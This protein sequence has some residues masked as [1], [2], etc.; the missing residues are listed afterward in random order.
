MRHFAYAAAWKKFEPMWDF[1]IRT[2]RVARMLP[3][4][5]TILDGRKKAKR[6]KTTS[7]PASPRPSVSGF[8]KG[9]AET[10][11]VEFASADLFD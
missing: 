9:Q 6:Q 11:V 1:I 7:P 3:L 10:P 8:P 4:L 2:K 5:E